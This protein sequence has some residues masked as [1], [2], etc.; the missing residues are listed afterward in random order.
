MAFVAQLQVPNLANFPFI[1]T[2]CDRGY[3]VSVPE[4]VLEEIVTPGVDGRRW[5]LTRTSFPDWEMTTWCD[6]GSYSNAVTAAKG[7][8]EAIGTLSTLVWGAADM[9]YQSYYNVMPIAVR[10]KVLAAVMGGLTNMPSGL[11]VALVQA[12][13]RFACSQVF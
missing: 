1:A 10:P 12:T 9:G 5:R 11:S 8:E 2:Q 3:P 4:A 6:Y 13:W 7:Y